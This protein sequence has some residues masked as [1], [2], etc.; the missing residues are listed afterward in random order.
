M[1]LQY[2]SSMF[3]I[4]RYQIIIFKDKISTDVINF[5]IW[6]CISTFVTGTLLGLDISFATFQFCGVIANIGLWMSFHE[7]IAFVSDIENKKKIYYDLSCPLPSKLY[8]LSRIIFYLIR[9]SI[10][11]IIITI[12]SRV[13]LGHIINFAKISIIKFI[14]ISITT[15]IFY[16]VWIFFMASIIK[17]SK[18]IPN[19]FS[20]FQFPLWFLGGFQFSWKTLYSKN[21]ILAYLDLANP[22]LYIN[23]GFKDAILGIKGIVPFYYLIG[24]IAI[25]SIIL[26]FVG[27]YR[28]KKQLDFV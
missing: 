20:R 21:K 23:E 3:S 7:T 9:F 5:L 11:T 27:Y 26:F 2:F 14:L 1:K 10:L 6:G 13:I 28:L 15:N 12:L 24:I 22:I 19:L 8:F 18:N 17:K 16:G 4:I 25:F